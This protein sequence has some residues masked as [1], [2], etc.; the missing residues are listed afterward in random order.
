[1]FIDGGHAEEDVEQDVEGWSGCVVR[2]G[3]LCMHDLFDDPAQGG[4]APW[5]AFETLRASRHWEYVGQFETLGVL[6]RR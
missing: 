5:R 6:R 3:Y 2:R 1:M 4:Q